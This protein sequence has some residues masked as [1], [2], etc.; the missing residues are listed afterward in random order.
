MANTYEQETMNL[1]AEDLRAD[2]PTRAEEPII[3]KG[4][5]SPSP[6]GNVASSPGS[7]KIDLGKLFTQGWS[8]SRNTNGDTIITIKSTSKWVINKD[9]NTAIIESRE[10]HFGDIFI[11]GYTPVN[12]NPHHQRPDNTPHE[13][14]KINISVAR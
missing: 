1:P 6:P 10:S 14:R 13:Q 9:G 12:H 7:I 11:T 5:T 2:E 8:L 3:V 4:G